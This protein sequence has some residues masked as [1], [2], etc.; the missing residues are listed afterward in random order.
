MTSDKPQ[1]QPGRHPLHELTL[2][3]YVE[4]LPKTARAR[5]E[6][7]GWKESWDSLTVEVETPRQ[8]F[9]RDLAMVLYVY[10]R[11]HDLNLQPADVW[12]HALK[13]W[14]AKPEDC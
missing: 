12:M 8:R 9:I 14:D 1:P 13:V 7:D 6:Y 5:E 3:E 10:G 2:E 11:R 4:I